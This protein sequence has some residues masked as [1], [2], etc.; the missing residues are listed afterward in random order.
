MTRSLSQ[1][2]VRFSVVGVVGFVVDGGALW[3]LV[4]AGVNP[5]LAR[6]LSF[7]VAVIVTW[8]LNRSWTF[9]V[10]GQ[11]SKG[12]QLGRYFAVQVTGA[13]ANYL[14]YAAVISL[15]GKGGVVVFAGFA[16]GSAVGA[17]INFVGARSIAFRT[18]VG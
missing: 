1:Q 12:R 3:L 16:L 17:V 13:A 8:A 10:I 14:I 18:T 4:G 6:L 15:F 9:G 11:G 7:P 2:I 5:Y